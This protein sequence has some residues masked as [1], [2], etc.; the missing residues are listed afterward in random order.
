MSAIGTLIREN[1]L[2]LGLTQAQLGGLVGR[3]QVAVS[4]WERGVALPSCDGKDLAA[5]LQISR[6]KLVAAVQS[7]MFDDD[8]VLRVLRQCDLPKE[9]RE[10][11]ITIY[12]VMRKAQPPS[13]GSQTDE[14]A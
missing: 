5:A 14:A 9:Q 11:L 6:D 12:Q 1:R 2:R 10:A 8:D 3:T 7:Q 4:E 13:A